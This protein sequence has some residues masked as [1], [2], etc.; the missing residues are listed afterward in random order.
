[1][2]RS[3]FNVACDYLR[4]VQQVQHLLLTESYVMD[5]ASTTLLNKHL[6]KTEPKPDKQQPTNQLQEQKHQ[7]KEEKEK[8]NK[9]YTRYSRCDNW[10][11][12][13]KCRKW[14]MLED[15][16]NLDELPDKWWVS[17]VLV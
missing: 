8:A 10:V 6:S 5:N 14:R 2:N 7:E 1:M 11:Q 15:N 9:D 16:V 3:V 12:C 4:Y 13:D 17:I